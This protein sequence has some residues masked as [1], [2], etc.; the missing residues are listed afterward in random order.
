MSDGTTS[1]LHQAF[2]ILLAAASPE[3]Q[4]EILRAAITALIAE[5]LTPSPGEAGIPVSPPAAEPAPRTAHHNIRHRYAGRFKPVDPAR[6]AEL[7]PQLQA[8]LRTPD[9][10]RATAP[11]LGIGA[12]SLRRVLQG[13]RRPGAG[14]VAK[15]AEWL[16][17][18]AQP[19]DRLSIEQ[20]ERLAFLAEHEPAEIRREAHVT[21]TELEQAIAGEVVGA[22]IVARLRDYLTAG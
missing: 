5:E 15:A 18:Q 20:R 7:R 14:V 21:R 3:R 8:R 2:D 17:R 6:W 12:T 9:D 11:A 16:A 10:L 19:P 4:R 1:P 22:E 13:Q